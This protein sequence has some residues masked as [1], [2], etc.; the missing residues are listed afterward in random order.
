MSNEFCHE[1][2]KLHGF[3]SKNRKDLNEEEIIKYMY[4]NY[5][6]SIPGHPNKKPE[7]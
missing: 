6:H 2:L 3:L 5:I 4:E 7:S 1:V